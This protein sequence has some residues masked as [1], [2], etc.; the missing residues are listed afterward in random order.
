MNRILIGFVLAISP[1]S[2]L[3]ADI[4]VRNEKRGF[5]TAV[6]RV[7]DAKNTPF[8]DL[9]QR[10]YIRWARNDIA[11]FVRQANILLPEMKSLRGRMNYTLTGTATYR[12]PRL[13]SVLLEGSEDFGGAHP[14]AFYRAF[15]LGTVNGKPQRLGLKDF[16]R[17]GSDFKQQVSDAVLNKLML[18]EG[19]E[20]V[21]SGKMKELHAAQ[22]QRFVVVPDGLMFLINHYEAGP[23][24]AGRFKVRLTLEE[25]G[26]D[27]RSAL[28]RGREKPA[29]SRKTP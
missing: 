26:P 9:A 1:L 22:L 6:A 10:T 7:P 18:Q 17:S 8:S 5:Y 16:F 21:K 20:W 23:Y 4:V 2:A 25:L 15:T 27:F 24:A 19:A 14:L 28:I 3:A 12:S 29:Q 13:F 11:R